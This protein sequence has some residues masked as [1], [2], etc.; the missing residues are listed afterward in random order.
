MMDDDPTHHDPTAPNAPSAS[1]NRSFDVAPANSMDP[2]DFTIASR[3]S[4]A[5]DT[6]GVDAADIA[7]EEEEDRR[8][9][10]G[11]TTNHR[12]LPPSLADSIAVISPIPPGGE[13]TVIVAASLPFLDDDDDDRSDEVDAI[14]GVWVGRIV[15]VAFALVD[16]DR[17]ASEVEA[18]DE[19]TVATMRSIILLL[20]V[21]VLSFA[22]A[23]PHSVG[24]KEKRFD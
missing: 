4:D 18:R 8:G 9:G 10:G 13:M 3:V 2:P 6:T 20:V 19:I 15:V 17:K 21:V 24:S 16:D 12:T 22:M 11:E 1:I 5:R 14:G 7:S 23:Q